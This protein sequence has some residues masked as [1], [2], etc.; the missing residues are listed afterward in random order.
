MQRAQ[1][2]LALGGVGPVGDDFGDSGGEFEG[3]QDGA[4]PAGAGVLACWVEVYREDVGANM[5]A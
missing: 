4:Q 2:F 5:G 1:G 3:V